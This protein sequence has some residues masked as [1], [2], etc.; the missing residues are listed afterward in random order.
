[1]NDTRSKSK[2]RQEAESRNRM[3]KRL[4]ISNKASSG[5][6]KTRK[7]MVTKRKAV[8]SNKAPPAF[9]INSAHNVKNSNLTRKTTTT[10]ENISNGTGA[11]EI[12]AGPTLQPITRASTAPSSTAGTRR[13]I[14]RPKYQDISNPTLSMNVGEVRPRLTSTSALS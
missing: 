9:N 3:M 11:G 8:N 5:P 7:R 2:W 13:P 4:A 12:R 14:R 10:D 1:M 6:A